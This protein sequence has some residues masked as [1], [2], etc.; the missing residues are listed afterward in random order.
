MSIIDGKHSDGLFRLTG[1]KCN[2]LS[3]WCHTSSAQE[4]PEYLRP[5]AQQNQPAPGVFPDINSANPKTLTGQ[6]KVPNLSIVPFTG[7]IHEARAMEYGA[8]HAPRVDGKKGYGAFNW[9]EQKIEYMTYL[10]AAIRHLASAADREDIDPDTGDLKVWHLDLAKA[11]IGILIDA[12]E[13]DCVI[14]N[15]SPTAKG[16]VAALLREKR[17]P[18]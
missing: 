5:D 13:H 17:K 1:N 10:E 15:R 14:D 2:A 16:R 8:F 4:I 12:I 6:T 11:T 9:R 3:C 18:L 7:I